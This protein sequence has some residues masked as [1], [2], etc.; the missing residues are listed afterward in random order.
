MNAEGHLVSL[1]TRMDLVKTRDYPNALRDAENHKLLVGAAVPVSKEAKLRIDALVAAGAD[2][3]V[4]DARQGDSTEQIELVKVRKRTM[5]SLDSL[6]IETLTRC[7]LLR[8]RTV[9]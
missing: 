9:H 7:I 5:A 3:I 2:V 4:L 1:V 8:I 6:L